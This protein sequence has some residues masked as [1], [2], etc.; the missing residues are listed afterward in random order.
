MKN[1]VQLYEIRINKTYEV[2]LLLNARCLLGRLKNYI[3]AQDPPLRCLI[4]LIPTLQHFM[5][6][7]TSEKYEF[8]LLLFVWLE[9]LS[10][11][12]TFLVVCMGEQIGIQDRER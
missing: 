4:K 9:I 7:A 10:S 8:K 3:P 1:K 5:H 6:K 11:S 2:L 12:A